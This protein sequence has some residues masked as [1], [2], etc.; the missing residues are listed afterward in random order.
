M[1]NYQTRGWL[2]WRHHMALVV[3]TKLFLLKKKLLHPSGTE[4]LPLSTGEIVFALSLGLPGPSGEVLRLDQPRDG[5]FTS[6]SVSA[7]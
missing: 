4:K 1:G 3:L 7:A 2:G 6:G 5:I